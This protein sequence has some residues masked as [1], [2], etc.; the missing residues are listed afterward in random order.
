MFDIT[1]LDNPDLAIILGSGIQFQ[2]PDIE[3]EEVIAYADLPDMPSTSVSGHKNSVKIIHTKN[4]KKVLIFQGRY[5]LYEGHDELTV[6]KIIRLIVK[7]KAKNVLITNAAGGINDT[8]AVA[9]LMVINAVKN[10]QINHNNPNHGLYPLMNTE[11][12][13]LNSELQNYISSNHDTHTGMYTAV[14]GPN[15][16]TNAE[17]DLFKSQGCDTVGM[18]TYLELKYAKEQNI[19]VCGISVV[20]N[21]WQADLKPEELPTHQEV[22]QNS[23]KAQSKLNNILSDLIDNYI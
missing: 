4:N 18:S 1:K 15:Y 6:Q 11:P 8:F 22:L 19:N 2:Y 14:L 3:S 7:S 9:D 17:I 12:M 10:Y 23:Q 5:H 20:T 21:I 13:K 16:E